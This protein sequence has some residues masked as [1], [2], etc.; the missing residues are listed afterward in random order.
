[1][2][3]RAVVVLGVVFAAVVALSSDAL[4]RTAE[5]AFARAG[6]AEANIEIVAVSLAGRQT[7]LTQNP[8]W[9]VAP[10][11]VGD[12]RIAF[13][14]SRDGSDD[15]YV[16]DAYGVGVRRLTNGA[17]DHSGVALA[18]DLLWSQASWSPQGDAIAFDGSY[19][20]TRQ[21]ACS[22]ARAGACS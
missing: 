20:P 10:A 12:G 5:S 3:V 14:S 2:F 13:F 11:V 22:T 1:M 9:D 19:F 21:L 15:L 7:N 17:V 4:S 6:S 16:M 8:A 18:E